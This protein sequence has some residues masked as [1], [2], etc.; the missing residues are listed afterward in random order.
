MEHSFKCVTGS[1]VGDGSAGVNFSLGFRPQMVLMYNETDGDV[2]C[3]ALEGQ[4][5]GKAL[6]I[7][8][9]GGGTTD[10]SFGEWIT[11]LGKLSK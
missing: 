9:S 3:L 2:I 7:I 1:Y 8:D 10:L 11:E 6:L 5:D 4:G